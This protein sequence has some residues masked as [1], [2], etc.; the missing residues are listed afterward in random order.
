MEIF[1]QWAVVNRA[2]PYLLGGSLEIKLTV[3]L[4]NETIP[5]NFAVKNKLILNCSF[6]DES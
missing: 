6:I 3:F 4:F 5:C 2:L 1:Q